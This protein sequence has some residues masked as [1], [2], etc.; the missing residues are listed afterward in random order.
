[1][2][3]FDTR[4]TAILYWLENELSLK[5]KSFQLASSDA[6]FRRYFRVEHSEGSYIVMDAPPDK[7]N[8]APFIKVATLLKHAKVNVPQIYHKDVTQGF[9]L[10]DDFGSQCLL[11]QLNDDSADELYQNALAELFK[12]QQAT[13][14][15]TVQL[16]SY[17]EE[18]LIEELNL[19]YDWFTQRLLGKSIPASLQKELNKCL[20]KSALEQP[21]VCVHRDYHSRNLMYLK[22]NPVG[23]IDFQDAVIGAITYDLVSLLRDCYISWSPEQLDKWLKEYYQTLINAEMLSVPFTTFKRWFDLMGL[24]RHMKAIGIF[25]RL[26]LRDNKSTYLQD[27]PRT[28][29]YVE[30][31]CENYPE[32]SEFSQWLKSEIFPIYLK[33]LC[34]P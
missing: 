2:T 6:S 7:E 11:E 25:S 33:K 12:I 32:L 27:I 31:V 8:T 5:I 15:H 23:V 9:L 4:T 17:D 16:P 30:H 21:Q 24:Q 13:N 28:M 10:L 18:L 19:F 29:R 22:T 26:H 14:S 1:M 3:T 20:I 34:K